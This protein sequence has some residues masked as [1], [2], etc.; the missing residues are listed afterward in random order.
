MCKIGSS[1]GVLMKWDRLE[2]EAFRRSLYFVLNVSTALLTLV[3][4][5]LALSGR[6]QETHTP[7]DL[8]C[9]STL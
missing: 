9:F 8:L 6:A 7:K 1:D 5:T 2:D 4:H 3:A